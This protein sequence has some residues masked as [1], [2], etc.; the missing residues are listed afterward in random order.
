MSCSKRLWSKE[1][2]IKLRLG[3]SFID[4]QK[5]RKKGDQVQICSISPDDS[6]VG[7]TT[8][9]VT[10]RFIITRPILGGVREARTLDLRITHVIAMRP[11][12]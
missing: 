11:T 4:L 5:K 2:A 9:V 3:L 6:D 1:F 7:V 12:R 10:E 8:Q